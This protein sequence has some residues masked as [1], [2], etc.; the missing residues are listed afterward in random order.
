MEGLE[1]R[2]ARDLFAVTEAIGARYA[3]TERG[4]SESPDIPSG[5]DIFELSV[6]FL[7][8]LGRRAVDLVDKPEDV[9]AE[10]NPVRREIAVQEDKVGEVRPRLISTAIKSAEELAT[11]IT[12]SLTHRRTI[13]TLR[14]AQ[15]SRSHALLTIRI[16]NKLLPYADEG[17]LILV[18]WATPLTSV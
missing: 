5:T 16:K 11:L 7:E 12:T 8:L 15:S 10:G 14:N 9:D 3:A 4:A 17:Q 18:E 13:A 6:T 1:E 2:I